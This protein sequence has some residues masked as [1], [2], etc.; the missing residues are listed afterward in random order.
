[1]FCL[2]PKKS[3]LS[4]R[5]DL[6]AQGMA[7]YPMFTAECDT[8]QLSRHPSHL[9]K[10]N[11]IF[12]TFAFQIEQKRMQESVFNEHRLLEARKLFLESQDLLRRLIKE[13]D[14][15]ARQFVHEVQ[16]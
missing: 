13:K 8:T 11:T 2:G 15:R 1:M 10:L 16:R 7:K 5:F 12:S 4:P 6:T 14:D 3:F 9:M